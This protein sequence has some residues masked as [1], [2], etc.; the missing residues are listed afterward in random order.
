M[1]HGSTQITVG[2]GNMKLLYSRK[3]AELGIQASHPGA[4]CHGKTP[5]WGSNVPHSSVTV[6]EES[7]TR[8]YSP[9]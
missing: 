7:W 9:I 1:V 5:R 2:T 4:S 8:N 3:A 6:A